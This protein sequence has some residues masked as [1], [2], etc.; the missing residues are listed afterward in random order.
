MWTGSWQT[1]VQ[2]PYEAAFTCPSSSTVVIVARHELG[3]KRRS[4]CSAGISIFSGSDMRRP[5]YNGGLPCEVDSRQEE[6][7]MAAP[8]PNDKALD[9]LR[10]MLRMRRLEEHVMHFAED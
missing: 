9:L 4:Q 2:V 10:M 3:A 6:E 5:S 1:R 8:L 7:R